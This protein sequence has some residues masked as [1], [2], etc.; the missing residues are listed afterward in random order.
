M[1][2]CCP[3]T[4]LIDPWTTVTVY[5]EHN[6]SDQQVLSRQLYFSYLFPRYNWNSEFL[7]QNWL[8]KLQKVLCNP[9][10]MNDLNF[11]WYQTCKK[12]YP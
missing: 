1:E 3:V 11:T 12:C 8:K 7:L 9:T 6:S 4:R 10:R 5:K 2:G